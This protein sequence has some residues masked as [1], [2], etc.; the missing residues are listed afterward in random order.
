ML[1]SSV[2]EYVRQREEE[3]KLQK[4]FEGIKKAEE[5]Q[6]RKVATIE[7]KRFRERVRGMQVARV[8]VYTENLLRMY[9]LVY[10]YKCL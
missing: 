7:V 8:L 9:I 1:K 6:Q 2:Q 5:L 10:K 4:Q 3:N